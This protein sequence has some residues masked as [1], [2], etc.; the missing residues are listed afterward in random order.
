[1]V[2]IIIVIIIMQFAS[3]YLIAR[4]VGQHLKIRKAAEGLLMTSL[5]E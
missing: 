5:I 4:S 2:I 1:V 3:L